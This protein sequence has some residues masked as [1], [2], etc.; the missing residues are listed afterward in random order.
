MGFHLVPPVA[1]LMPIALTATALVGFFIYRLDHSRLGRAM[2]VIFVDP[3][4]AVTQGATR[5]KTSIFLQTAAGA[6][7]ALAGAIFAPLIGSVAP[8]NFGFPLLLEVYCFLF[9]G[10]YTTMWGIVVFAPLLWG[11]RLV[12]PGT[13]A[14]WTLIIYGALLTTIVVLRPE[15][16]ITKQVLRSIRLNSQAL[17]GRIKGLHQ[18][19]AR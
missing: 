11:L 16:I 12:L 3:N 5:Y 18:L 4:V 2:E 6:I 19:E 8:A 9:I 17:L 7:G 15:G 13:I 1:H 10:G 14:A